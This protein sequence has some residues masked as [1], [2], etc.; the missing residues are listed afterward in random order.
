MNFTKKTFVTIVGLGVF[1]MTAG[2]VLADPHGRGTGQRMHNQHQ[3]IEQGVRSGQLNHR[4]EARLNHEQR[5]IRHEA[6]EYRSDGVM[7]RAERADLRHDQNRA[8]RHIYAEKHDGRSGAPAAVRDPGVNARQSNQRERI[9][10]GIRSGELTRGEARQLG[11]EQRAI[12]Q[13]ERQYKS[14]GVLT[15]AERK[16]LQQDLNVASRDIYNEKHDAD[17]R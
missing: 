16:D 9:G 8:S 14:D 17:R 13:E 1:S 7:T 2:P 5:Q 11:A 3:R 12:R 15:K 10:Q 4:E 6:R